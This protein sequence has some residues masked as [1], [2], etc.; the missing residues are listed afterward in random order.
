MEVKVNDRTLELFE[1]ANVRNALQRY[2]S[3]EELDRVLMRRTIV[4]D[5]KGHELD[6]DAPLHE[7]MQ[8]IAE[9]PK[10]RVT[11]VLRLTD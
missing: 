1:G 3:A 4:Y 5:D 11:T 10:N 2:F 8:L 9:L 6:N 7:G